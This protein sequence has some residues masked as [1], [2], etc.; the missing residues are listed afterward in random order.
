MNEQGLVASLTFGGREVQGRGFSII[1]ML[2]YV[3]E[4]CQRVEEAIKTLSRIPIAVSQNVTLLDRSGD[5][6][7]LF[8]GPDREP[9]ISRIKVCTN[10]QETLGIV[11]DSVERQEVV[12]A[13]LA[14]PAISLNALSELFLKSPLYSRHVKSTT[15]YTAVYRPAEGRVDY[16]WPGKVWPQSMGRFMPGDYVH[17]YGELLP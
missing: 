6:A 12:L 5:Y 11:A 16:I 15:A 7:T 13:A 4:T 2:R 9:T 3:L 14:D 1:L 8:L 10:H 17:D